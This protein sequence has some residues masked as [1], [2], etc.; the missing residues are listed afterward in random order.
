MEGFF[1]K[2]WQFYGIILSGV[3]MLFFL[4]FYNSK[5]LKWIFFVSAFTLFFTSR[6]KKQF[7]KFESDLLQF[8]AESRGIADSRRY[9][10]GYG[11]E[12]DRKFSFNIVYIKNNCDLDV[13]GY[14]LRTFNGEIPCDKEIQLDESNN[15]VSFDLG[16]RELKKILI[17]KEEKDARIYNSTFTFPYSHPP[18]AECTINWKYYKDIFYGN[19]IIYY[20]SYISK[21]VK[22]PTPS[23]NF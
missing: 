1:N 20:L 5:Y 4:L 18:D 11:L 7:D 3:L 12:G 17:V 23:F 19:R 2:S 16:S 21:V 13:K 15:D 10:L 14:H 8:Y 9:N 22:A 6:Y